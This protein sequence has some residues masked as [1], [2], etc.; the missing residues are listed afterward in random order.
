MYPAY[1][2]GH[3]IDDKISQWGC[4]QVGG[5]MALHIN[6]YRTLTDK[7]LFSLRN[8]TSSLYS[9]DTIYLEIVMNEMRK[10]QNFHFDLKY[11]PHFSKVLAYIVKWL[12]LYL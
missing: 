7:V 3:F 5:L 8:L 12:D 2:L 10:N 4:A 1:P 11:I 9:N 6:V